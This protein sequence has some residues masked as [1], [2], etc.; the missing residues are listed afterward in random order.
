MLINVKSLFNKT[1]FLTVPASDTDNSAVVIDILPDSAWQAVIFGIAWGA[2]LLSGT[3]RTNFLSS[4]VAAHEDFPFDPITP[5]ATF[6]SRSGPDATLGQLFYHRQTSS[7]GMVY[8]DFSNPIVVQPGRRMTIYT[9]MPLLSVAA[10]GAII[11]SLTVRGEQ[12][13]A[14]QSL[15]LAGLVGR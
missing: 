15:R 7:A 4:F 6:F 10:A 9:V 8:D 2:T 11:L 3:D 5:T 14:D 1:A 12:R 13:P